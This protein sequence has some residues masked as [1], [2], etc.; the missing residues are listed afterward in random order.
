[1]MVVRAAENPILRPE[2]VK[3]SRPDFEVIGVFNAA[4]R[5]RDEA[6]LLLRVAE[7]PKETDLTSISHLRPPARKHGLLIWI[8]M[9]DP[10]IPA[11]GSIVRMFCSSS[12]KTSPCAKN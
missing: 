9:S 8:G 6:L 7:R 4:A 10:A 3:P 12:R 11:S 1:M 2:D 5:C